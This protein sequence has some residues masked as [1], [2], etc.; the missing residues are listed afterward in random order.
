M[1]H[2]IPVKY[3]GK[4]IGY[5]TDRPDSTGSISLE[6]DKN[7]WNQIVKEHSENIFISSRHHNEH[8]T[9]SVEGFITNEENLTYDVEL[10]TVENSLNSHDKSKFR[11]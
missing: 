7:N 6:I 9:V 11:I 10:K 5:T 8:G 2:K 1:D 3:D 4:I